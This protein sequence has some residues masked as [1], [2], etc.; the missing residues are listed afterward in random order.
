M[1]LNRRLSAFQKFIFVCFL[2]VPLTFHPQ[3]AL[4][5]YERY[6]PNDEWLSAARKR[7]EKIRKEN[8]S[9]QVL[10]K[11]GKAVE[12]SLV[13]IKMLKHAFGFG[14]AVSAHHLM[15]NSGGSNRYREIFLGRFNK[16]V[17]HNDLKSAAWEAGKINPAESIFHHTQTFSAL[18]FL[19]MSNIPVRGHYITL[20]Q[21]PKNI[22]LLHYG[23][24]NDKLD[25]YKIDLFD[26]IKEKVSAVGNLVSEW[27]VINHPLGLGGATLDKL[28]GKQIFLDIF[29]SVHELNPNAILYLNEGNILSNQRR[30]DKYGEIIRYLI[31]NEAPIGGI[32]IMGHMKRNFLT[33]PTEIMKILD[34]FALFK[35]PIQITEFDVQFGGRGQRA[36]LSDKELELQA[37][38]TRAFLTAVFSHPSVVGIV[39][40]GFWEG[41]HWYPSAALYNEDWSV[42]PNGIV[43]ENL[44]HKEWWTDVQGRTNASGVF[45]T[46]CFLGDY[47]IEVQQNRKRKK[48]KIHHEKGDRQIQF[49]L[50]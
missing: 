40:W 26:H 28:F 25:E 50:D 9:V 19:E 11:N 33:S 18:S 29:K 4:F 21:F 2:A 7:I 20:G 38:Y 45:Q 10:D 34:Q 47:E 42:K 17:L 43:W 35:L 41:R 44:V 49:V 16:S 24:H 27:D 15:I 37:D 22:N 32:G 3:D 8:I 48:L 5:A 46:R 36:F 23:Y 1:I 14:S 13:K 31:E 12:G 39:L 6:S 30:A